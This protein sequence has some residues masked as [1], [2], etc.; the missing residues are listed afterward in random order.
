VLPQ[1]TGTD[2]GKIGSRKILIATRG[3][4]TRRARVARPKVHVVRKN[5]TRDKVV[6]GTRKTRT[7]ENILWKGPECKIAIKDIGNRRQLRWTLDE[8]DRKAFGLK[9]VK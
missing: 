2:P 9:F 5:Q 6:R 1:A 4:M 7:N 8:F 3:K